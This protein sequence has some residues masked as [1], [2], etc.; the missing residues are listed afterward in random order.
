[1]KIKLFQR[2]KEPYFWTVSDLDKIENGDIYKFSNIQEYDININ[3]IEIIVNKNHNDNSFIE[4]GLNVIV[5]DDRILFDEFLKKYTPNYKFL[6]LIKTIEDYWYANKWEQDKI[7]NYIEN[8]E[9]IKVIWDVAL[10]KHKNFY[11]E[12]KIHIQNYYN[13]DFAF[14]SNL[15]L[16]GE[17]L[18]KNATNKNVYAKFK[19]YD[20]PKKSEELNKKYPA[21]QQEPQTEEQINRYTCEGKL[22]NFN[23]LK[24]TPKVKPFSYKDFKMKL[25][26]K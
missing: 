2:N 11:F 1:M 14:P 9:H 5:T 3:N 24:K 25:S 6:I 16:Y 19:K 10:S 8:C 26:A 22:S 20:K 17:E 12:P 4:D 18:Y 13:F 21:Q 15:F 23:F 7:V